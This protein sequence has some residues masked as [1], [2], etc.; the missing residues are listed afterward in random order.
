ML[1]YPLRFRERIGVRPEGDKSAGL[2]SG[3]SGQRHPGG[4]ML[5]WGTPAL[6]NKRPRAVAPMPPP[7]SAPIT[8]PAADVRLAAVPAAELVW[9]LAPPLDG[10]RSS[11]RRRLLAAAATATALADAANGQCPRPAALARTSCSP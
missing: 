2:G 4:R 7:E 6:L 1:H 8:K 10:Q 9:L 5:G 3:M 11:G